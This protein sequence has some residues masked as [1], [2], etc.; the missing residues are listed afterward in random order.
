MAREEKAG[1]QGSWGVAVAAGVALIGLSACG[2]D[3]KNGAP[4]KLSN[5]VAASA[6]SGVESSSGGTART[7]PAAITITVLA[8]RTQ[9]P[10]EAA[11]VAIGG[12]VDI[13]APGFLPRRQPADWPQAVL[14]EDDTT[15]PYDV[16]QNLIYKNGSLHR[17]T[18][19]AL[20]LSID[21][22]VLAADRRVDGALNAA[23]DT[24]SRETPYSVVRTQGPSFI[25]IVP[26]T[27]P[28]FFV[29][30]TTVGSTVEHARI[31]VGNPE[32]YWGPH[33]QRALTHEIGHTFGLSDCDLNEGMMC[34]PDP[35]L[36]FSAHEQEVLR[37]TVQR[38]PGNSAPDVDPASVATSSSRSTRQV[39]S[40][41]PAQA[42]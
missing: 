4:V 29:Y 25:E 23:L 27:Q 41:P 16:T 7:S 21:P 8:E 11:V 33:L 31:V 12:F 37:K 38:A 13:T 10:V 42:D 18:Q 20:T 1:K 32:L 17:P 39:C 5:P 26:G 14:W 19:Q 3:D 30:I 9:Q 40:L 28:G 36:D 6:T 35:V 24:I 22:A 34:S 2:R 15:L